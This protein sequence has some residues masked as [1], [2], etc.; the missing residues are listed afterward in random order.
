MSKF[1]PRSFTI[2][3]YTYNRIVQVSKERGISLSEAMRTLVE[4]GWLFYMELIERK[5]LK[6]KEDNDGKE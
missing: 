4:F 3:D 2:N 1:R 6:V 5:E